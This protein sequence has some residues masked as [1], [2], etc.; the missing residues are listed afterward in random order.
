MS[1]VRVPLREQVHR[2]VV[3]RIVR[4]EVG[5]GDRLSDAALAA[6]LGVSRT[7]VREALVRLEQEGFLASDP[8]RGFFV[9]PL[10]AREVEEVYPIVWTLEGLALRSAPP[11][12]GA[13]MAELSRL[14]REV[15]GAADDPT[16]RIELDVAWHRALTQGCGNALLLDTL[17]SLKTTI[18]RYEFAWMQSSEAVPESARAHDRIAALAGAGRVDEAAAALEEHWRRGVDDLVPWLAGRGHALAG[19]S[20]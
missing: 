6:E 9:K 16:R 11:L 14:S 19:A 18:H 1:I 3:G 10:C 15:P 5:P 8:G 12:S 17:A 2:A 13:A 7:P 20:G 4:D